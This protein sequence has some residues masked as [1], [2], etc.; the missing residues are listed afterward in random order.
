[1]VTLLSDGLAQDKRAWG[2]PHNNLEML[3]FKSAVNIHTQVWERQVGEVREK[4]EATHEALLPFEQPCVGQGATKEYFVFPVD[5]QKRLS[6]Q[7]AAV[8][9]VNCSLD[10]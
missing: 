3:I 9:Q 2:S 7:R 4:T 1:M 8:F 6:E 5:S 10:V